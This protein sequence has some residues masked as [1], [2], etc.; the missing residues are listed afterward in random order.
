MISQ[1]LQDRGYSTYAL[2]KWHLTP[3]LDNHAAGSRTQ[4]PLGRGFERFYGFRAV[5]PTSG[6]HFSF[7]T[8]NRYR[9]SLPEDGNHFTKDITDR[10]LQYIRDGKAS[11]P[12][13]PWLMYFAPGGAHAPHHVPKEWADRYKGKFDMGYEK[14]REQVLARQIPDGLD[15]RGDHSAANEPLCECYRPPRSALARAGLGS[16]LGLT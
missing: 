15:P 7:R 3:D 12:D 14:I 16:S 10:A 13:K 2:G 9:P 4:R 8:T 11:D 6:T 1:V 5:R